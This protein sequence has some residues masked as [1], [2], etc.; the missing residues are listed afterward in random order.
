M[1]GFLSDWR[2]DLQALELTLVW[3]CCEGWPVPIGELVL[4]LEISLEGFSK[5]LP[6][7]LCLCF[8]E[9]WF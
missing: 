2:Q 6:D 8:P 3:G 1:E 5:F 4:S 7:V 9:A